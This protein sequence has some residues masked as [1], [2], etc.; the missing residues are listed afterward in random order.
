MTAPTGAS[1]T[2]RL[3]HEWFRE[4][5]E[6]NP[7]GGALLLNGRI[8]PYEEVG[9]TALRWAGAILSRLPR[10][11]RVGLL[12]AHSEESYIGLLA[13]LMSGAA[14]I[15]LNPASPAARNADL[16]RRAELDALV[17]DATGLPH[18]S[19]IAETLPS[20]IVV[21][22]RI[23]RPTAYTGKAWIG[24]R[25]TAPVPRDRLPRP[26]YHDTAYVLF[27]S[28]STGRP[29]GVPITHANID[30]FLSVNH[31]RYRLGHVD[32]VSQTFEQT[33]DVAMMNL[34]LAWGSGA[35][36]C[37]ASGRDR[38]QPVSFINTRNITVW[39]SVPGAI[40]FALSQGMLPHS[41]M[42][43]LKWSFFAGEKLHR[44]HVEAWQA[45][46]PNSIV[47]NLY[48][49][50][51]ATITC[52]AY[53]WDPA[54]SA[55]H[56][57]NGAVPI[58]LPSP[59]LLHHV[60]RGSTDAPYGELCV[61]GP[62]MFGGYLDPSDDIGRFIRHEGRRWF[63]TGDLVQTDP[64]AGLVFL[65]R[66]DDQVK[67]R[68]HRVEPGE[69]EAVFRELHRVD[70]AVAVLP[71]PG[72]DSLVMFYSGAVVAEE[73]AR[74]QLRDRVPEYMVPAR[75]IRLPRIPRSAHGKVD[76]AR[77]RNLGREFTGSPGPAE[78]STNPSPNG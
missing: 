47:E 54:L 43:A 35:L 1:G 19:A 24:P 30:H 15:L 25:D 69:V 7:G 5:A 37:P 40:S 12:A 8:W 27:T 4:G 62:Q 78:R 29:K 55:A 50:T 63:R 3:L 42:N 36:L 11:R 39:S 49:P 51:E 57:I 13:V 64:E 31:D 73:P 66:V 48:G 70:E 6:R 72:D 33:F 20:L 2:G 34:F 44:E 58:G 16:A 41:C 65:G 68:G 77:L 74:S 46:A 18:V 28:G 23:A 9:N 38:L 10:P 60:L 75:I 14:V 45:A 71:S 76:R 26:A 21:A 59:G 22:P 53:R 67:V 32:R 56:C 61:S 17:V 52:T